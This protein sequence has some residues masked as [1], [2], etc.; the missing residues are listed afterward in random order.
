[1]PP[2]TGLPSAIALSRSFTYSASLGLV[3]LSRLHT[4]FISSSLSSFTASFITLVEHM[5]FAKSRN[6]WVNVSVGSSSIPFKLPGESGL[7][8]GDRG[9]SSDE[10]ARAGAG[11][12]S[13]PGSPRPSCVRY[14][15]TSGNLDSAR[16]RQSLSLVIS[17]KAFEASASKRF[18]SLSLDATLSDVSI[19]ETAGIS[20]SLSKSGIRGY[21]LL[22]SVF[23]CSDT[24]IRKIDSS[25]SSSYHEK[26]LPSSSAR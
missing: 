25:S 26:E 3:L 10:T 7:C 24:A 4:S 8:I 18:G 16:P 1:M 21:H 2:L 23:S 13:V 12:T 20:L 11:E 19:E 22:C 14:Q 17:R 15:T 6:C 9:A 5:T